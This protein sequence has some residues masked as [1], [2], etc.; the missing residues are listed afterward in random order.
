[1]MHTHAWSSISIIA[2]LGLALVA[3]CDKQKSSDARVDLAPEVGAEALSEDVAAVRK[4]IRTGSLVIA[5]DDCEAARDAV[6][7]LVR[8]AG[9]FVASAHVVRS[10]GRVASATLVL[11]IPEEELDRS[12]ATLTELGTLL[13]ESLRAQD[14]TEEYHDLES[15]LRNARRLEARLL[16]LAGAAGSASELLEIEREL[17]RVRERIEVAEGRQRFL[18][19][20]VTLATLTVELAS[21]HAYRADRG[22]VDKLRGAWDLSIESLGRAGEGLVILLVVLSPWL[23][24]VGVLAFLFRRRV[25][26]WFGR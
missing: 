17:G 21:R 3:G 18:D 5:V 12:V 13:G 9:G 11:R 26:R 19:D 10:E 22:L 14:V 4:I 24:P 20:Q 7:E 23:L 2:A 16:E 6:G 1:M 8:L 15:R 25:R